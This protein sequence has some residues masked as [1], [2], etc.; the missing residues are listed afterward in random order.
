MSICNIKMVDMQY[1]TFASY[2]NI[3]YLCNVRLVAY[4]YEVDD[5]LFGSISYSLKYLLASLHIKQN[6]V[7]HLKECLTLHTQKTHNNF[8]FKN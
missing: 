4:N 6:N 3:L 5:Y 1:N 8:I 2:K 7:Q